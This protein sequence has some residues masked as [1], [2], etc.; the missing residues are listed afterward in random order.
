[1]KMI[2]L[3]N[4]RIPTEKA[5]GLQIMKMAEA[6]KNQG[7]DFELVVAKR[8][9]NQLEK[10]DPFVYYGLKTKFPIKKIWLFDLVEAGLIFRKI[11]VFLQNSSFALSAAFYLIFKKADLIYSR[12][13]FSVFL[14]SL[15]K[16]N[17][18]LELHTFPKSKRGLYRFI[19]KRVKK[20]VV[21][22][23]EI[24]KL[25]VGLEIAENKIIV[26]PDGVDI[27]QF[28]FKE[29]K[30]DC[31][32][33]VGLLTDK[34]IIL[35]TGHLFAWKGVYTLAESSKFLSDNEL[36]VFVGGMDYDR[37][38][39]KRF[40]E[41]NN[42]KNI[43]FVAH[44]APTDVPYYLKSADVVILPNSATKKISTHYTSPMKMFEY[45]ASSR[46]I[47]ASEL[48]SLKEVLNQNNSILVKPDDPEALAGGI[49]KVLADKVLAEGVVK[50][51]LKDVDNYTWEKR[52]EKILNFLK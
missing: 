14:L 48:P 21:I 47:V 29:N 1:M 41:K 38:K 46:P 22:T 11:G 28:M 5:H 4:A 31:R 49:K 40:I 27:K 20:I 35:Y 51:A 30:M 13:E 52:A 9:N 39:L 16:K 33:R 12:D 24:K 44:R 6:F 19:F 45:M 17:I 10:I 26:C 50:Q 23:G 15:F 36:I 43:L 32:K 25:I 7:L 34:N 18:V 3:A 8:A 2:Y 37:D 42:L